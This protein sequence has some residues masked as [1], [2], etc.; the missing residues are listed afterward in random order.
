MLRFIRLTWE[1]FR[2]AWQALRSN[3][4]RTTLSLLGVSVGIFAITTVFTIVD[5]LENTIREDM[6]FIGDD[7]MYVQKFPWQF[8]GG[9]YPWWKYM[10]RPSN[11]IDEF[12]FLEKNLENAAAVS[13]LISRGGNTIKYRSNSISSVELYGVSQGYSSITD[14]VIEE[15]RYFSPQET[16]NGQNVVIIG[17][18]IKEAL[19]P[20]RAAIGEGV[21]IR[22]QKYRV[23][24]VLRR[25]GQN[26]FGNNSLDERVI[27]P[28]GA[29]GKIY[30]VGRGGLDPTIALKGRNDDVGLYELE[31]EA[32]GYLRALRSLKPYEED[33][34]ALNRTE[35]FADALT[36]LFS[37]IS[38]AGWFIGGFSI[39]VGGFGIA[40]I[41]FVSVRERTNLIGIQKSLGAKNFFI[42]FQF[43]FEAVMLSLVGGLLGVILVYLIT[44]LPLGSLKV[45]LSFKNIVLG[46]GVASIVGV[47]AGIIPA[48][49]A[50]RLDPVE[51]IR[52]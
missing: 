12:K 13:L 8:G 37:G 41:M 30:K 52:A 1:S 48:W 9:N 25:E 39:L 46:L 49:I 18:E 7:V 29:L 23:I 42:L 47:I 28:Y 24:G 51:A 20:E 2:F 43:L 50:S 11:T 34:F 21:K 44:F 17:S 15:G 14:L 33:D 27:M 26:I 6:S 4:L 36:S 22:G 3:L 38:F 45:M 40:N 19:F 32:R 35:A 10:M 5:S 16:N 31:G